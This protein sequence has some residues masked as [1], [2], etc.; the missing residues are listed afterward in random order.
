MIPDADSRTSWT[1]LYELAHRLPPGVEDSAEAVFLPIGLR[2]DDP[3]R[4]VVVSDYAATPAGA[5]PFASTGGDGVHFSIVPV[6]DAWPV[7]MTV[8]MAF[9]NPNHVVGGDVREFL[10]LGCRTGYFNLDRLA[11][12]WGRAELINAL[13]T[14]TEPAPDPDERR[15]L[16][17][18]VAEFGL[19]PWHDVEARLAELQAAYHSATRPNR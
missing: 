5:V 1:R 17:A 6:A 18:L 19:E 11:Y 15:L 13:Q 12:S 14:T 8:P 4:Q 9:T 10:A 2:L 3:A 7:V 16:T